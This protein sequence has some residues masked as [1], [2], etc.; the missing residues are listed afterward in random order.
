LTAH[1]N[2]AII[3]K[4]KLPETAGAVR[5]KFKTPAEED[6][7][8]SSHGAQLITI[9]PL[10]IYPGRFFNIPDVKGA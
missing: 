1:I 10:W 4:Q 9:E 3:A 2:N 5:H 8:H 7:K 6:D